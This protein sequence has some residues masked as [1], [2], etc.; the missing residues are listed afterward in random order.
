MD[1]AKRKAIATLVQ[2]CVAELANHFPP[3]NSDMGL[4]QRF[5]FEAHH[6]RTSD[7]LPP[8]KVS[9]FR[10]SVPFSQL[11]QFAMSD[12]DL[13]TSILGKDAGFKRESDREVFQRVV[14]AYIFRG[15]VAIYHSR[16]AQSDKI[17]AFINFLELVE[18]EREVL[19]P[20]NRLDLEDHSYDLGDFGV[21]SLEGAPSSGVD[22]DELFV[23]KHCLLRFTAKTKKYF[24]LTQFDFADVIRDK[25]AAIRM[26]ANPF[27][28]FNHFG[29][30]HIHPWEEPLRDEMFCDRFY[31]HA[32]K[33]I[34]PSTE[35][36]VKLCRS[37]AEET[38]KLYIASRA[39]EWKQISPWRLALNRLDDAVFKIESGSTD[40]LLDVVIG[41]ESVLVES[42]STQEST[43]KVAVRAARFLASDTQARADLF[44]TMKN[45][46]SL[47]SKIAHG[48]SLGIDD[49]AVKLLKESVRLLTSVL[50]RMLELG[51]T[52]L[53]L[54]HIDLE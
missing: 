26:A 41:L 20:L 10:S 32:G 25:V 24:G 6:C 15:M 13:I 45:L 51:F 39:Q 12:R 34:S 8:E 42:Q 4:A 54:A 29:I 9:A 36:V 3:W 31:G 28:S 1:E 17:E 19:V 27:A 38:R 52:E 40:A 11:I 35:N 7:L 18:I 43:H 49:Q 37:S 2:S 23:R 30:S 48:K 16:T 50:K 44:K 22:T 5:V 21:L 53:N 33:L 14:E 47:R 46:Y